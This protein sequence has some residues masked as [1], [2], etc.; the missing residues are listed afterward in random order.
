MMLLNI[1]NVPFSG[2]LALDKTTDQLGSF[3]PSHLAVDGYTDA[4]NKDN[5]SEHPF[6]GDGVSPVWWSVD[7][8]Q[9]SIIAQIVLYNRESLPAAGK[10]Y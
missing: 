2:N 3:Y 5:Q 6:S 4:G 8:G 1:T 10:F 9:N 7:L